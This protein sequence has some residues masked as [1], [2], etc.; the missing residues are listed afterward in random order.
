MA[1][2][3]DNDHAYRVLAAAFDASFYRLAYP[4]VAQ[5]GGEPL[6]HYV[7]AGWR[8]LRDP[9]P[10]FSS[11]AYLEAN[12]DVAG[13]DPFHHYLEQGWREGRAIAASAYALD[14]VWLK[15]DAG[16]AT[17][18]RFDPPRPRP[19]VAATPPPAGPSLDEARAMIAPEFDAD[20]Y[21]WANSDVADLGL[22]PLEHY[23]TNGWREGR[24]PNLAFSARDYLE[25]NPDVGAAGLNPFFHW[26]AAGRAEGRTPGYDLGFRHQ[27]ISGL[28]SMEKRLATAA[29]R[30]AKVERDPASA[31]EAALATRRSVRGDLHITFSHDDYTANVGGVQLCLQREDAAMG[32]LGRD[33]LHLFPA[34][35][36]PIVRP[37]GAVGALGVLL[38]G[39]PVG[40]FD[41]DTIAAAL[42][43]APTGAQT[44][45]A[46]HNMLGHQPDE[47]VA[48][49][50]GAGLSKGFLWLHDFTSLCA[51]YH[52]MR[53]EVADCAAPPADS[54]ACH[55]C[56]FGAQRA[57]HVAAHAAL[58]RALDL[59]VAAP[60]QSVYDLWRARTTAPVDQPYV[61]APL[62]RLVPRAAPK[63]ALRQGP[64]RVAF[65]GM[66]SPHKGWPAFQALAERF[67]GD[68]RYEFWHLASRPVKAAR[69]AFQEVAVTLET[70]RAMLD[71][72][73]TLQ[74]DVAVLWSLCR[75]TFSYTAHEAVAA[76]VAILTRPDSG[77]IAAFVAEGGHGR[78]LSD[79]SQLTALFESGEV[80]ALARGQRSPQHADLT[81]SALT[82][83]LLEDA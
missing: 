62:A 46:I 38:N 14:Y 45:F 5:Q 21:L 12:P 4:D 70:P 36:W 32:A 48:I 75:E 33:H 43:P 54:P 20:Y 7:D 67:S 31:L 19:S 61:I 71:A 56:V 16:H 53:N 24:N 6:R 22:D 2:A 77:N 81:M 39:A 3:A 1:D 34:T 51:G 26:L 52:L 44:S 60:S 18:W 72:L 66:P 35:H 9:A 8:E 73:E 23:L 47:V 79:E 78:V 74:I 57:W 17:A 25:L 37:A 13:S 68:P 30:A 82:A 65:L 27:V 49:L 76:G 58:F 59:T 42:K 69:L 41:A 64:L 63:R 80:L 15:R 55:L 10:W 40:V 29:Q 50:R 28:E 83:D 11:K